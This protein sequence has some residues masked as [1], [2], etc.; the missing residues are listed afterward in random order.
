ACGSKMSR[1]PGLDPGKRR[2]PVEHLPVERHT[3]R[4]GVTSWRE[5]VRSKQQM[6][7]FESRIRFLC[8]LKAAGEESGADEEN[9]REGNL[10]HHEATQ[11]TRLV[12]S[13]RD[14]GR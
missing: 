13:K 14:A 12:Q 10:R 1:G 9:E 5:L 7:C 8:F 3:R 4:A 6:T 2:E 11:K